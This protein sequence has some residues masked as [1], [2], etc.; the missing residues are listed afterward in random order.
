MGLASSEAAGS[1]TDRKAFVLA[2][3]AVKCDF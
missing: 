2:K 3:I 1:G